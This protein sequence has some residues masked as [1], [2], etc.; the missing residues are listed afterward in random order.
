M[1]KTWKKHLHKYNV[2][3]QKQKGEERVHD[4]ESKYASKYGSE[5]EG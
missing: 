5:G 4:G 2:P 1:K 3:Q